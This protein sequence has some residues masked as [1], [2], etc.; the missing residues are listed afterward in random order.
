MPKRLPDGWKQTFCA[1]I[2]E[3]YTRSDAA[4]ATGVA[5]GTVNRHQSQDDEFRELYVA[6][7]ETVRDKVRNKVWEFGMKGLAGSV[8][9]S[10]RQQLWA[11]D[12]LIKWNLPEAKETATLEVT[13]RVEITH[14]RRLTLA[15]ALAQV[16]RIDGLS[17]ATRGELPAAGYLLAES[18]EGE[19]APS[20]VPARPE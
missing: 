11:L 14:E 10:E 17:T 6:A 12:H 19:P 2:A 8:A 20:A 4:S 13:G 18:D 15:D 1:F 3:G 7:Q 9:A 5:V 16:G